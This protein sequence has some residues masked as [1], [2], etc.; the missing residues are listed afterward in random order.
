MES[1]DENFG[2]RS[3]CLFWESILPKVVE[4]SGFCNPYGALG[5]KGVADYT[6]L[7]F[8]AGAQVENIFDTKY[9]EINGFTTRGRGVYFN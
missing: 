3:I 8:S 9:R 6:L 2:H 5:T 4:M 7:D 1:E